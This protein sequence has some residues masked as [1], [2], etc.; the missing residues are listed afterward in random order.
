MTPAYTLPQ[1]DLEEMGQSLAALAEQFRGSRWL[2]TGGTGFFGA[3]LVEAL[4]FLSR[5]HALDLDLHLVTRSPEAFAARMPHLAGSPEVRAIAGD[6]RTL[7]LTGQSHDF[8]IH[9]ATESGG[10]QKN[11]SRLHMME[12]I[13]DGTRRLLDVAEDT[14]VRAMLSISSGAVYGRRPPLDRERLDEDYPGGPLMS[15]QDVDHD[16]A[17]RMAEALCVL[18]A[19]ERGL[20]VKIARCFAF[21]GPYLPL[22]THFAAGNFIRDALGGGPVTVRGDGTAIRSYLYPVD[23]VVW[24]LTILVRGTPGTPYNVGSEEAVS[25]AELAQLIAA[26][27]QPAVS[28]LVLGT[29]DPGRPPARIVPST[30]RA[31]EAL[32]LAETVPLAEA[33][34]RTVQWHTDLKQR[35]STWHPQ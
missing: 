29:P 15:D 22:G 5:A 18:Y 35:G 27:V 2:I 23:L 4:L 31:R 34:R 21:V 6:V 9:A 20:P 11:H 32:G 16:E 13:V 28:V 7:R 8:L 24:L 33:I 26:S 17:K 3:W 10:T 25:V 30:R 1:S 14:G 12:T 19:R